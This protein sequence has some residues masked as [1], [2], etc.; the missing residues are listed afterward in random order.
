MTLKHLRSF[1]DKI[2]DMY[3]PDIEVGFNLGERKYKLVDPPNYSSN[4]NGIIRIP[5]ESEIPHE[6][7]LEEEYARLEDV[8]NQWNDTLDR[9]KIEL[10][11]IGLESY[12]PSKELV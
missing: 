4:P 10:E 3:S 1:L 6:N 9:F 12:D 11:K 2:E 7:E 8:R 5:I